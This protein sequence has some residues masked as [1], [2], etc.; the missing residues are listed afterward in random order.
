[1]PIL[2]FKC[3][4]C[5]K[6]FEWLKLASK[7]E[8]VCPHCGGGEFERLLST[9]AVG[10]GV[11]EAAPCADSGPCAGEGDGCKSCRFAH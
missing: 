7:D 3:A 6:S 10:A 8:P 11:R 4:K 5:G 1:L 2:E 9:F